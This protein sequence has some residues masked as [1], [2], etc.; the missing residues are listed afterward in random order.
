MFLGGD[1]EGTLAERIQHAVERRADGYETESRMILSTAAQMWR[2][3]VLCDN[4]AHYQRG[5]R[6][7]LDSWF[8]ELAKL[9]TPQREAIDAITSFE[10]WH[11]LR[12]H[13]KLGKKAAINVIVETLTALIPA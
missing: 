3:K 12:Y 8:P 7:D 2:Y 4:Y 9:S 10:M 5:L 1:R 11:R 13:Q 6:K